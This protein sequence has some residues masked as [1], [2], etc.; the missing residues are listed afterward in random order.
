MAA[1][2]NININ[3]NINTNIN[4]NININIFIHTR[5]TEIT[6]NGNFLLFATNGKR[7]RKTSV[8]L[9]QTE[10]ENGSLLSLN[11]KR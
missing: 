3:I 5:K 4:I 8:C 10:M 1:Y 2:M 11:G 9:L 6:E 7:K